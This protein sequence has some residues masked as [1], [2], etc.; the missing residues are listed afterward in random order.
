MTRLVIIEIICGAPQFFIGYG[1][2]I[3]NTFY[4]NFLS[5]MNIAFSLI[6]GI[7]YLFVIFLNYKPTKLSLIRQ[8]KS[9]R[10]KLLS[11]NHKAR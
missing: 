6:L 11:N 1:A 2:N 9:Y 4:T 8:N 10:K 5:K 3:M 7:L